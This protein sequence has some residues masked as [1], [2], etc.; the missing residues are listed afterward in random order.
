MD[1]GIKKSRFK[2]ISIP[3]SLSS[4]IKKNNLKFD[5]I[6]SKLNNNIFERNKTEKEL[7]GFELEHSPKNSNL[8]NKNIRSKTKFENILEKN[9]N[10]KNKE[11]NLINKLIELKYNKDSFKNN[12]YAKNNYIEV[13][14]SDN[15]FNINKNEKFKN[16]NI[17]EIIKEYNLLFLEN[18][19]IKK[20]MIL[21]QIL[22]N[23][24]KKDMENLQSDLNQKKTEKFESEQKSINGE[25]NYGKILHEKN[26]LI[27]DLQNQNI[28]L[29]NENKLLKEKLNNNKD[30]LDNKINYIDNMYENI[31][32]LANDFGNFNK[33]NNIFINNDFLEKIK[34]NNNKNIS[35][36]DKVDVINKF[37][38]FLKLEVQTLLNNVKTNNIDDEKNKINYLFSSENGLNKNNQKGNKSE[39]QNNKLNSNNFKFNEKLENS[40]LTKNNNRYI[41]SNTDLSLN[42]ITNNKQRAVFNK[43]RLRLDLKKKLIEKDYSIYKSNIIKSGK[44]SLNESKEDIKNE[45]DINYRLKELTDLIN[46]N[47]SSNLFKNNQKI[48]IPLPKSHINK[49][50][51]NLPLENIGQNNFKISKNKKQKLF[52][53]SIIE[54]NNDN[55][56]K[57]KKISILEHMKTDIN[58][59]NKK[60]KFDFDYIKLDTIFQNVNNSYILSDEIKKSENSM[61]SLK[62]S[63]YKNNLDKKHKVKNIDNVP[64]FLKIKNINEVNGLAYEVMKPSFL[65]TDVSLTL[66]NNEDKDSDNFI[67]KDIKK[68]E[69]IKR[70]KNH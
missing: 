2:N 19:K 54:P 9:N 63:R 64:K 65:R 47:N 70:N 60:S 15:E 48:K 55:E 68:Y 37:I 40:L 32:P 31:L 52:N 57:R 56:N 49:T 24:M 30:L 33:N 3:F 6:S 51:D 16:Q 29:M 35:L 59:N 17:E 46:K 69:I 1:F 39:I 44:D 45:N 18:K 38:E 50:A 11:D 28:N 26:D 25:N 13:L 12:I 4:G 10:T 61:K 20:S 23:E 27:K 8:T 14:K 7:Y 43:K 22:V 36:I 34:D 67:F 66:N 62:E 58:I 21:Q 5:N 42:E 53:Y 41:F